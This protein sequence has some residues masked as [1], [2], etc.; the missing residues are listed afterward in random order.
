[1]GPLDGPG[2]GWGV[3]SATIIVE[4]ASARMTP[5]QDWT[6]VLLAP[7]S[8]DGWLDGSPRT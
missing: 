5:H 4:G 7:D 1:M 8:F 3:L 2:E 6:P